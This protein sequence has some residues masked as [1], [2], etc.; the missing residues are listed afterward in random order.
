MI[1]ETAAEIRGMQ[2]HSSSVVAV[3]ATRALEE[4]LD[5]MPAGVEHMYAGHGETFHGDVRDVVETALGRAE[6]REPKY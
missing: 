6:K 2:T 5:R 3:K 4:L 1:D